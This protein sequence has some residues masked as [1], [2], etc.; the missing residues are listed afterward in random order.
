M[1]RLTTGLVVVALCGLA[2]AAA[3]DA[4]RDGG[5]GPSSRRET[6]ERRPSQPELRF[7]AVSDELRAE[8]V[9]GTITWSDRACVVHTLVLPSLERGDNSGHGCSFTVSPGFRVGRD[10]AVTSPDG[11]LVARCRGDRVEVLDTS[12]SFVREQVSGCAPAWRPDAE[13]TLVRDGELVRLSDCAQPDPCLDVVVSRRELGEAVGRDPWAFG[14]PVFQEVAWLDDRTFAAVI[15]DERRHEAL[16]ALFRGGRFASAP[17]FSY[18]SLSG[19]RVSPLGSYVAV[20]LNR[21]RGLV[22]VD[23]EGRYQSFGFRTARAIAW[24]PDE[25]WTVVAT[26]DGTFLFPTREFPIG[27][28]R[29]PLDAAD[30]VWR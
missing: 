2:L 6:A 21:G 4:I 17:P 13:L 25:T 1:G 30:L 8:G 5:A 20:H 7:Q 28:I 15:R 9:A 18:S 26:G 29:L 23:D 27:L 22:M 16:I 3:V 19:L 14:R 12:A 10:N 24:S 11:D